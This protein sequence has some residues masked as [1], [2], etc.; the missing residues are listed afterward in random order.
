IQQA[1]RGKRFTSTLPQRGTPLRRTGLY[2]WPLATGSAKHHDASVLG[3]SIMCAVRA[4]DPLSPAAGERG[5]S[6]PPA[7]DPLTP[8]LSPDAEERE[9]G[10]WQNRVTNELDNSVV[11]P[12]DQIRAVTQDFFV[13]AL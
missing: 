13:R 11:A 1:S 6:A 8:T 7:H 2:E 9:Q 12:L 4:I 3:S 5:R 10:C